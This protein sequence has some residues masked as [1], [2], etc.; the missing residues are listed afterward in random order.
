MTKKRRVRRMEILARGRGKRL[1]G[2]KTKYLV[3]QRV[4]VKFDCVKK[5][6]INCDEG[7]IVGI[8]WRFPRSDTHREAMFHVVFD[9]PYLKKNC[10]MFSNIDH[11][12][13]YES[14]I[15]AL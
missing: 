10:V 6:E 5:K 2:L 13:T 12:W 3:G 14:S 11:I 7:T 9:E 1:V 8:K 4:K 15:T